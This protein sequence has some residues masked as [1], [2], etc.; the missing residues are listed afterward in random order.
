MFPGIAS[1]LETPSEESVCERE[2]EREITYAGHSLDGRHHRIFR[3]IDRLRTLLR[4]REVGGFLGHTV[5][6]HAHHQRGNHGL[7][8]LCAVATGEILK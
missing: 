1:F 2:D 6:H 7:S 3:R 4:P 8:V 5:S